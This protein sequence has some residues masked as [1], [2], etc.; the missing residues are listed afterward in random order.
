MEE[1]RRVDAPVHEETWEQRLVHLLDSK[2]GWPFAVLLLGVTLGGAYQMHPRRFRKMMVQNLTFCCLVLSIMAIVI[3]LR[4]LQ[5]R[6]SKA[7]RQL[8]NEEI[9]ELPSE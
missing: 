2:M 6:S 7:K 1:Y 9:R 5:H 8:N 4:R 3:K